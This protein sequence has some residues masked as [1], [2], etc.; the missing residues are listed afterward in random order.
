[1]KAKRELVE[2]IKSKNLKYNQF[3]QLCCNFGSL[4]VSKEE[5]LGE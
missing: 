3:K 1:M 2:A 5:K 4:D